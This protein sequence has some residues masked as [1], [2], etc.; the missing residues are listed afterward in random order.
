MR[1]TYL[2]TLMLTTLLP[3]GTASAQTPP[4]AGSLL[5]Q[6][7]KD[8][9]RVV[10]GAGVAP[11][12]PAAPVTKAA[13][14]LT[15]TVSAFRFEG[16]RL[17]GSDA[18]ASRLATFL[19][20]PL[21]FAALQTAADAVAQ[22]YRDAG[23]IVRADLPPQ[24]IRGGV[25]T[26]RVVEAVLG[27]VR[28]EG[29]ASTR[30]TAARMRAMV[31]AAQPEGAPLS[32]DGLDRAVLLLNDVPGVRASASLAAGGRSGETDLVLQFTPQ[33]LVHGEAVVDNLG[34]RAIGTERLG[35]TL[36]IDGALGRGDQWAARLIHSEGSDYVRLGFTLPVGSAG[37]RLGA[38]VSGFRYRL[39]APAFV[40]LD[41][42]GSS[43]SAGIEA[44]YPLIRSRDRNLFAAVLWD[45]R[46]FR[47]EA[48]AATTSDYRTNALSVGL[49]GNRV[50]GLGRGGTSHARLTLVHGRVDLDGSPNQAADAASARTAGAFTVL[51]YVAA[52]DQRLG[53]RLTLYAGLAGQAADRNLDSAE[54]FYLGG[55][56]GV[57]A[58]PSG[59]GGGAEG[60]LLNLEL[61]APLRPD[62]LLVGFYDWGQVRSNRRNDFAGAALV[63]RYRLQGAGLS[64]NWRPG[65]GI[66]LVATWARR[67]GS[68]AN[69]NL[70]GG[71]PDGSLAKNRFWLEAGVSF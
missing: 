43:S 52:R 47:N 63:N 53:D 28:L 59:E 56:R 25:V 30:M 36:R 6:I 3:H 48:S 61:R 27:S 20:R 66:D 39:V 14:A 34:S 41:A 5:Q 33:P 26:I 69:A 37:W 65:F 8:P 17:L 60:T 13:P 62:L 38:H 44:S 23:W 54:K 46:R 70:A 19:D 7:E 71:D 35:G 11:T 1:H 42:H 50:D 31:E 24:D 68:N 2:L 40:S 67:I 64:L 29:A 21:D 51:R 58:Y 9:R 22:A 12:T 18:L 45:E 4:D 57:R 10:P 16:N 49:H 32:V 55:A 15:V